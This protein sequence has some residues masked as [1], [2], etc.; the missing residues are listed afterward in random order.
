MCKENYCIAH[1]L[2]FETALADN[3]LLGT[4]AGEYRLA[5]ASSQGEPIAS[6]PF[7]ITVRA[8]TF[9]AAHSSIEMPHGD[10]IVAGQQAQLQ[11]VARDVYGNEVGE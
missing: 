1:A 10:S 9:S 5:V 11:L 4:T 3:R 8:N 7:P 6:S 2:P